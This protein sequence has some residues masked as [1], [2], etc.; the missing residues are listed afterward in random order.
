MRIVVN[1]MAG[2]KI[3]FR[4]GKG[5]GPFGSVPGSPARK[6]DRPGC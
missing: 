3:F 5:G 1:P 4:T 2:L 6:W